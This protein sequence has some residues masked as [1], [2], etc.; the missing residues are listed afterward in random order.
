MNIKTFFAGM[1]LLFATIAL[2]DAKAPMTK[3]SF[4]VSGNCDS[5][6]KRIEKAAK[7]DGVKKAEWEEAS[8]I[9]TVTFNP[10][11]ITIDQIEQNVAKAGHDTEKFKA[12]DAAYNN[13][14]DCCHYDRKK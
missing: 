8:N 2:A 11:K 7:T 6:K 13:L 1:L 5:C 14:P 12:E 10:L 4:K 3:A 9:L